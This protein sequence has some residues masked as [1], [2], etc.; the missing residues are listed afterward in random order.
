[1]KKNLINAYALNLHYA[2]DLVV[3]VEEKLMTHSPSK[4]LENHPAFSI[5]HLISGAAMTARSLGGQYVFDPKWED[6]FQ[7]NGPGDPRLPDSNTALYPKKEE[8]LNELENQHN[9]VEKL[10][11]ELKDS[12]WIEPV[13]WRLS[14]FLPTLGDLLYYMCIIHESNHL[15]QVAAW[16][17]AMDLPSALARM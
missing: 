10:I 14:K 2:K 9:R 8:L 13:E 1:M 16:R 7:R 6:L 5:G 3:D 15:G 17:R 4:G 12:K 11:L